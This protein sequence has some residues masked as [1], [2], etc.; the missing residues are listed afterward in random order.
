MSYK[1][2]IAKV[3]TRAHPDPEVH[4]MQIGHVAGHDVI[5][6]KQVQDGTLGVFFPTDGALSAR[7]LAENDLVPRFDENGVKIGGGYFDERGRVKAQ[8]FRGVKS[9]GYWTP[10]DALAWTGFDLNSLES[11][12]EFTELNGHQICLKYETPATQAV[13]RQGK[14]H[15]GELKTFRMHIDTEQFK[16]KADS[17]QV[18][19]ILEITEKLHGSSQRQS[20]ALVEVVQPLKWWQKL[21][22]RKP[23]TTSTWQ[24]LVGSRKVILNDPEFKG[25]WYGSDLFRKVYLDQVKDYLHKGETIYGEI[26]GYTGNG[27]QPIMAAHDAGLTKDKELIKRFGK[28]MNYSYGCEVGQNKFYVYRITQTNEDG[29]SVELSPSQVRARCAVLGLSYVPVLAPA[30][31]YDGNVEALKALVEQLA[32]GESTLDNRHIREGVIIRAENPDGSTTFYKY[33]SF[34][35]CVMEGIAKSQDDYVDA[36][37]SA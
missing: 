16:Y 30:F 33:K 18:G 3:K 25:G 4:S 19:A 37:E 34:E 13:K 7:M 6:S 5:I 9:W 27:L 12:Y 32:T 35:F 23:T 2:I 17:I 28:V 36:E 15:R 24:A 8:K 29:V 26:V 11:G 22:R 31:I 14:L 10:L 21:L 1:A 20:M